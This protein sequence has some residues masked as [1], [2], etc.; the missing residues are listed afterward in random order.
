MVTQQP[1]FAPESKPQP[2]IGGHNVFRDGKLLVV[3]GPNF[4]F[5]PRCIKTG[6][7]TDL[8]PR[9]QSIKYV[10]GQL[11]WAVLG[12]AIGILIAQALFGQTLNLT[13]PVSLVHL[14]KIYRRWLLGLWIA[15]GGFA[16]FGL[17]VFVVVFV[18]PFVGGK[19]ADYL[20]IP[21]LGGLLIGIGG[22]LYMCIAGSVNLLTSSK[23][24]GTCAWLKGAAPEFLATL[25][26]WSTAGPLGASGVLRRS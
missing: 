6:L 11:G 4:A 9:Q 21:T 19:W 7:T 16:L 12:G 23:M 20:A 1:L 17:A 24:D 26:D 3:V 8:Q 5:P 18:D 14:N 13:V 10:P 25:P 15:L 2:A 22:I